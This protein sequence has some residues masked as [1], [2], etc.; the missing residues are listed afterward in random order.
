M[1]LTAENT[2][3][4]DLGLPKPGRMVMPREVSSHLRDV[5]TVMMCCLIDTLFLVVWLLLQWVWDQVLHVPQVGALNPP[6][7][8]VFEWSF[9]LST[10]APVV[11]YIA[12]DVVVVGVRAVR[13]VN[14]E[15]AGK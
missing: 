1:A 15:M 6:L 3:P 14:T 9:H 10:L 4:R 5:S 13:I 11:I 12:R 8:R 7:L 2:D